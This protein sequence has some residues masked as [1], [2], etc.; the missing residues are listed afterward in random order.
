MRFKVGGL[1]FRVVRFKVGGFERALGCIE[2]QGC[3]VRGLVF[4]K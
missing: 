3:E 2:V 4:S 1:E